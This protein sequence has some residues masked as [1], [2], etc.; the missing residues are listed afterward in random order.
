MDRNS[1]IYPSSPI[2]KV[3]KK[4]KPFGQNSN[5]K[6]KLSEKLSHEEMSSKQYYF[7]QFSHFSIH[8]E[9]LKDD[10]R[11]STYRNTIFHNK[12]LFR[13]KVVLDVGCGTGILSLFAAKAGASKV[14]GVDCS[15][16]CEYARKIAEDNH[17]DHIIT[18]IRGK[19]EEVVLPV[20]KVDV[21][22]SEWMGYC[23]MYE[24]TL[25]AVLYARDKWLA[26]DGLIFPDQATLYL[27]GIEDRQN[28]DSKID[29]WD[30]V[31]GFDMTCM[32]NFAMTEPAVDYVE[33]EKVAT[34]ACVIKHID[35]YTFNEEDLNFT[36]PFRLIMARDDYV[37]SLV[38][39]FSV[40]F[41]HSH[42]TTGF[43][44][45]PAASYTHWRQAV[46]YL[47]DYITAKNG[48]EMNGVFTVQPNSDNTGRQITI[49]LKFNGEL[50]EFS[51]SNNYRIY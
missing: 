31:H 23:L 8:E 18:I 50:G 49:D 19:V 22:I 20:L 12:H 11:T 46:F 10:V 24:S 37:H 51:E 39:F 27:S 9:M 16:I 33:P 32:K 28:K 45:S 7:D 30:N 15:S 6:Q 3:F 47:K 43:T 4:I 26:F 29:W 1:Q 42:K 41:T 14:I 40:K 38:T 35:M 5:E 13:G 17:L 21:I 44:T 2:I 25:N 48:E 36:Q 34:N